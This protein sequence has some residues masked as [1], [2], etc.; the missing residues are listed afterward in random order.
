VVFLGKA[1]AAFTNDKSL[2][3][4]ALAMAVGAC[5]CGMT[6]R[7]ALAY[8]VPD[9]R[10]YELVSPAQKSGGSGGVFALGELIFQVEQ[11]GRPLQSSVSGTSI[12][13]GGEDFFEPRL[14]SL[15]EYLSSLT[16]TSWMTENLTPVVSST[17]ES[18]IEANEHRGFAPDLSVGII[19]S[20]APISGDLAVPPRYPNLY[21]ASGQELRSLQPVIRSTPPHRSPYFRFGWAH[22]HE[23]SSSFFLHNYL[24]FGGGNSG[25]ALV[26]AFSHVLF[27]ANDALTPNAVDPGELADNLYEWDRGQIRLVNVLPDGTTTLNGAFGVDHNDEFVNSPLPNLSNVI[28]ADGSKIFWTDQNSGNL[29]VRE[30]GERTRQVDAAVGGGGEYQ[31]ASIDGSKVFFTKGGHLDEYQTST[32]IT[33]DLTEAGGVK[34]VLGASE[35]GTSI[36]FVATTVLAAGGAV[37]QPNLYLA[38]DGIVTFVA[39]LSETDN[40]IAGVSYGTAL[41]GGDWFRTFAGR[42]ARVSPSGRYVAFMSTKRLT[43][44][45]NSDAVRNRQDYEAFLY[46][47]ATG[48][49]VCVSCNV[50][51]SRPT[52]NTLLPAPANGTYQQRY[53]NDNG[54]LFFSTSDAVLPQD[55]NGV[56]DVYEYENGHVY[57][58]S[59]GNTED[60]AVFA[61]ASESGNDVFF[62]TRQSLVPADRDRINDLYDA[63]VGGHA[64]APPAASCS[65]EECLGLPVAPPSAE[66]PVSTV[67]VGAGNLMPPAPKPAQGA[68]KSAMKK[69]A[70][71]P[72]KKKR[73]R[74]RTKGHG[75]TAHA[76]PQARTGR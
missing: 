1:W 8:G 59:P 50:D 45:D 12:A 57:L 13:Y 37:G 48:A 64:E 29:Y 60:E 14:G 38:R 40:E 2:Y 55:T 70:A 7:P 76:H 43:G 39:T 21:I 58:I 72:R 32:E 65:G 10:A 26:P 11:L 25:T 3:W 19:S 35:D 42:T 71:K 15:N 22:S 74:R 17:S 47:S 49:L 69:G 36:Y 51:G 62:T 68:K 34:G 27:A 44:Y 9:Q 73:G 53:L 5:C 54:Q 52:E 28:S 18:A 4:L 61:D 24:L 46:D 6:I 20:H 23:G 30:D 41:R 66:G 16:G 75:R 67:F 33:R 31:T 63:R 56:S